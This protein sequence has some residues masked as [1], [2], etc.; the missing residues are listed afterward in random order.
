M[1]KVKVNT[2][3]GNQRKKLSG[4]TV[5]NGLK[6]RGVSLKT[7][8]DPVKPVAVKASPVKRVKVPGSLITSMDLDEMLEASKLV[9]MGLKG[10]KIPTV[11][12]PK[13]QKYVRTALQLNK[14][15]STK[16]IAQKMQQD[17]AVQI[18]RRN[19]QTTNAAKARRLY[20]VFMKEE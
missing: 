10:E 9:E 14:S 17:L 18:V 16:L 3:A 1:H 2:L 5:Q 6:M 19:K 15:G 13:V 11:K 12:S 8:I 7:D 20:N 4:T